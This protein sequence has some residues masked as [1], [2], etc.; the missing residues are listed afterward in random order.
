MRK[1]LLAVVAAGAALGLVAGAFAGGGYGGYGDDGTTTTQSSSTSSKGSDET[2]SFKAAMTL[3][4]EVPRA[5]ATRAG[6]GGTF[7]AKSTESGS[8][9][10]F[11]W[12]LKYHG[13][14]GKAVAAHVHAGKKGKAGGVIVAL[15]GP[16][17]SGQS[18]TVKIKGA[19]EES[20]EKG[21][22]YV[23]VH[24]AKNAAGEIRGQIRLVS[25]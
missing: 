14:T 3:G 19:V 15:C 9:V 11:H 23:N 21:A 2:Y 22:T 8:T 10:T 20:L 5:K 16:C 1:L 4:Q 12:V 13:L 17:K 24:T 18:G 6:A 25:S 7:T